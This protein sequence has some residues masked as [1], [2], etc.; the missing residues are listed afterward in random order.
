MFRLL[1]SFHVVCI[2]CGFHLLGNMHIW[3][4]FVGNEHDNVRR[5]L[6]MISN[7]VKDFYDVSSFYDSK[8]EQAR[9]SE[10]GRDQTRPCETKWS[11]VS[12]SATEWDQMHVKIK[13]I[14][15]KASESKWHEVRSSASEC[16]QRKPCRTKGHR[17]R[18]RET[19]RIQMRTKESKSNPMKPCVHVSS[20][21][22]R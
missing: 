5:P 9:P 12:W 10:T 16:N 13:S 21:E 7:D 17:T 15:V 6:C 20:S 2:S 18:H 1:F 19:K 3:S 4:D 14:Q 8:W 11:H 22:S